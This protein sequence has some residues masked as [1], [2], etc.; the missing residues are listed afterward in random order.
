M[1]NIVLFMVVLMVSACSS[2]FTGPVTG[3]KYNVD[4]GCTDDMRQYREDR[5]EVIGDKSKESQTVEQDCFVQE[6]EKIES[7]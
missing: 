7:D 1:K 6:K 5:K 3:T 4:M 2:T